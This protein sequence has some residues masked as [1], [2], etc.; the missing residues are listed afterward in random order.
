MLLVRPRECCLFS[1]PGRTGF[2]YDPTCRFRP[3]SLFVTRPSRDQPDV[4]LSNPSRSHWMG[5]DTNGAD[6]SSLL[7]HASRIALSIGFIATSI[8]V[9]IGVLVGAVMGYYVGNIDL[10]ACGAIEIFEAIPRLFLL[11]SITAFIRDR[12]IYVMMA[13]IG[14]T[15]WTGYARFSEPNFSRF[16]SWIMCRPPWPRVFP[17]MS[18]SSGIC[19][20]TP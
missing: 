13:V 3:G 19:W 15:S 2:R 14:A 4:R 17:R 10:L 9:V 18:F 20:P 16:A 12:N 11:I 5:T 7:L 6:V 1:L 8:S